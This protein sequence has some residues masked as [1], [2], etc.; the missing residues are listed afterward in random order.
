MPITYLHILNGQIVG[1]ITS[2][3]KSTTHLPPFDGKYCHEL[4]RK[5]RIETTLKT[6][7]ALATAAE[8]ITKMGLADKR[9]VALPVE[10]IKEIV[11]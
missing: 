8:A 9:A 7:L 10:P 1:E 3:E 4:I 6:S 5:D 11:E 2:D